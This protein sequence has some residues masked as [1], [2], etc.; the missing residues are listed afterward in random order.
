MRRRQWLHRQSLLRFIILHASF[1][2]PAHGTSA[3]P[4]THTPASS[5]APRKLIGTGGMMN[6]AQLPGR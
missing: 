2:L 4:A 5:R 6:G 1:I 3:T